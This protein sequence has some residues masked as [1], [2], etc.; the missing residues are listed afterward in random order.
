MVIV[1]TN[2]TKVLQALDQEKI[3][4]QVINHP[5]VYTAAQADQY[6]A[7]YQFIRAKNLFLHAKEGYYLVILPDQQRLNLKGLRRALGIHRL[8]FASDDD[9]ATKLGITTGAVSPFN[10]MNNQKHDVT[11]VIDQSI[12][13]SQDQIGCHPNDNTKTVIL[14]VQDMIRFIEHG[15]NPVKILPL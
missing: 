1:V 10:L 6:V 3:K 4:Y 11:V 7:G 15:G 5:P 8:S 13:K 12:G 9:L 2:A 14:G